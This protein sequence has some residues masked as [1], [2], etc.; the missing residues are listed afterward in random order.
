MTQSESLIE[1]LK[2]LPV[3]FPLVAVFHVVMLVITL[4]GFGIAGVLS[5][6]VPVGTC[7]VWL[8]YGVAW[9]AICLQQRKWAVITYISLTAIN[10]VLQF[11]LPKGSHW[12][13]VGGTLFPFDV[14]MCFFLTFYYKRFR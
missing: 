2:R 3:L 13:Q 14:L 9:I 4:I 7:L 11:L 6:P 1:R 12:Q 5:E 8:L 10:L